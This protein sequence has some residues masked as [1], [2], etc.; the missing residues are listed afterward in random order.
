MLVLPV[1]ECALLAVSSPSYATLRGSAEQ[2]TNLGRF[3]ER[4]LGDCD[5]DDPSFDKRTCE[6]AAFDVQKKYDGKVLAIDV[7]DVE[8]LLT[9]AE[10][11]SAKNAYR[12]H[13]T[14][15][16]GERAL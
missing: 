2:V 5:S 1:L 13:L 6:T 3:L 12:L 16:F 9:L 10:F 4:Y 15:F 8:G 14:P 11:E 7:E